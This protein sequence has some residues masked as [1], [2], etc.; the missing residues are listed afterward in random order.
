VT[1]VAALQALPYDEAGR[2][3]LLARV[4]DA[5]QRQRLIESLDAHVGVVGAQVTLGGRRL[6]AVALDMQCCGNRDGSPEEARRRLEARLIQAAAGRALRDIQ[7]HAVLVGGDFNLISTRVPLDIVRKGLD[8]DG[9]DLEVADA[10]QL[11][12]RTAATWSRPRDRFAPGRL[13]YVLYSGA[14][15]EVVRAFVFDA[16]D[17]SPEWLAHHH[18]DADDSRLS[19]DHMP[20]VVDFRWK[21]DVP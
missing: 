14:S 1:P 9:S 20:V 15:L 17:L 2:A 10:L 11:D 12:G 3:G 18:L 13:D 7:P 8:V 4:P 16:G 6:L 19:S 21:R 5:E